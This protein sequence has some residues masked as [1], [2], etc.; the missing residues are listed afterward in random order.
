MS[1]GIASG[2]RSSCR[3]DSVA[4]SSAPSSRSAR[5]T[6]APRRI[7]S[8]AMAMPMPPAPPVT[9]TVRSAKL[10]GAAFAGV[11]KVELEGLEAGHLR[12]EAEMLLEAFV[13]HAG[14]V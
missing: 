11:L 2:Y 8:R 14:A 5:A 12:R 13:G 9:R 4:S 3:N 6:F 1:Q 10:R 7:S